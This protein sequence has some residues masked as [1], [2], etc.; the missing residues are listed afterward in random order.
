MSFFEFVMVLIGL[1]GAISLSTILTFN[2]YIIR[3]WQQV[4]NPLLFLLLN[5]W[6]IFNVIGH[7]S[8]IW[9]YRNVDLG[10]Y[11]STFIIMC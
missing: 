5:I 2:G 3:H 11:S 10:V 9:A 8:G 1:V 4:E 6:L 7:I